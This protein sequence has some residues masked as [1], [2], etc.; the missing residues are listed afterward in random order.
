MPEH[1][2][3]TERVLEVLQP[4]TPTSNGSYQK[5]ISL[6]VVLVSLFTYMHLEIT[7]VEQRVR[8]TK[9][10]IYELEQRTKG[11]T[12]KL[13]TKL[14]AKIGRLRVEMGEKITRA[15][16]RLAKFDQWFFWWNTHVPAL[17]S[18]Q[19]A[20]ITSL[21]RDLYGTPILI[22]KHAAPKVETSP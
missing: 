8:D 16:A 19:S 3:E 15:D 9:D 2:S 11:D 4:T 22:P 20:K 6:V 17:N 21:E 10:N 5:T 1:G 13:D 14:Q 18:K 7:S 12:E